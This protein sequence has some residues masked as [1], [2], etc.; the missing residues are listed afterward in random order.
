MS[1]HLYLIEGMDGCG[2]TTLAKLLT[3]MHVAQHHQVVNLHASRPNSRNWVREY[4]TPALKPEKVVIC[5][6]WHLGEW[7][8]PFAN[9]KAD[10][11]YETTRRPIFSIEE[12]K[13]IERVLRTFFD[14]S[15]NAIYL[16]RPEADMKTVREID[17]PYSAVKKL[18]ARAIS[19]SIF[20]WE[21]GSLDDMRGTFNV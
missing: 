1:H 12:M 3:D 17:Y 6:R 9:L 16:E 19:Y 21:C 7:V 14:G 2:K 20:L 5:D 11:D 10:A 18:Y 15:Y 4:V 13:S 8:W